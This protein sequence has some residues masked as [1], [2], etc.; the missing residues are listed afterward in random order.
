MITSQMGWVF[1]LALGLGAV[2]TTA[3]ANDP[4]V[5]LGIAA[6]IGLILAVRG[7][8]VHRA[9]EAA[10]ISRSAVASNNASSMSLIWLWGGLSVFIIYAAHLT[11]REWWHFAVAFIA[12]GAISLG[13]SMML[14]KDANAGKEDAT[15]LGLARKLGW[16]QLVGM[17]AT[18]IG[19][20][21][22]PDKRFLTI[23]EGWEDWAANSI[24]LF[25]A[26]GLGILSAYA[27]WKERR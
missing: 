11:W 8:L 5:H 16:V 4:M 21:V 6:L 17:I 10:R 1:S 23:R 25:G 12:V 27:L 18:V 9:G 13:F 24:F 7:I 26:A 2:I 15:M 22:D 20:L 14:R 19:L 3:L